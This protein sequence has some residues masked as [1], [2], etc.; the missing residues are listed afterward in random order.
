MAG[1]WEIAVN[2]RGGRGKSTTIEQSRTTHA[3]V[4]LQD[5]AQQSFCGVGRSSSWQD[6]DF[7]EHQRAVMCLVSI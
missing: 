3:C 2:S 1:E 7:Y 6:S 5:R 4:V